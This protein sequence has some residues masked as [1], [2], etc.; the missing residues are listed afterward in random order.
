MNGWRHISLAGTY[1]LDTDKG[2]LR[3]IVVNTTA[4]GTITVYDNSAGSGNVIAVLKAS[5]AEGTYTY[6]L[7]YVTGLT[8]VTAAGSDITVVYD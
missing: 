7:P 2:T 3:R 6:E 1:V 4:N 8:V 5:V